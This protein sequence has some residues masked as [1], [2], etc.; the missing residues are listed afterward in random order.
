MVDGKPASA[1]V[2]NFTTRLRLLLETEEAS[3][4]AHRLLY[5][6]AAD[7]W[8]SELVADTDQSLADRRRY[9]ADFEDR[10]VDRWGRAIDLFEITLMITQDAGGSFNQHKRPQAIAENDLVFEVLVRL[11]ARACLTASE[12]LV[13]LKTGHATGA[14]A[15]WRTLHELAVVGYFVSEHGNDVAERYLLHNIIESYKAALLY[16]KHY[17]KL[18]YEPPDPLEITNLQKQRDDLVERYGRGFLTEYGWAFDSFGR[19]ATFSDLEASIDFSHMRPLYKMASH[20]IHA[21]PKGALWN[22]GVIGSNEMLLAGP[23]NAGLADAGHGAMIS[24]NQVTVQLLSR[25]PELE[26]AITMLALGRLVDMAGKAFLDAHEQLEQDESVL[27]QQ[28][29]QWRE[30]GG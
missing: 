12:V 26:N 16:Q 9:A 3:S 29:E 4:E 15:R 7:E 23:S 18:G 25:E 21:N 1:W 14:H 13:L 22:L 20:G 6:Q 24:L 17:T 28:D 11:H 5:A 10:L 27:A 30:N 19:K 2:S 8:V